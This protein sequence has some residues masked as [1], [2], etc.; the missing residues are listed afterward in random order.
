V[1]VNQDLYSPNIFSALVDGFDPN[2]AAPMGMALLSNGLVQ[3][4]ASNNGFGQ[5]TRGFIWQGPV[6]WFDPTSALNLVTGWT[7]AAGYSGSATLIA[8]TWKSSQEFGN[9]FPQ[10]F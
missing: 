5:V 7:A 4:V 3:I 9:E 8:T 2:N 1:S 10:S 6:I